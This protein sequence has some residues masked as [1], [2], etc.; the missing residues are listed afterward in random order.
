[1]NWDS[2]I[3]RGKRAIWAYMSFKNGL[4]QHLSMLQQLGIKVTFTEEDPYRNSADMFKVERIQSKADNEFWLN[5]T[6]LR[7]REV[8][9]CTTGHLQ[10][11]LVQPRSR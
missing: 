7:K 10:R 6:D 2:G 8:N 3:F 9:S 1:L 11:M 4:A 5:D